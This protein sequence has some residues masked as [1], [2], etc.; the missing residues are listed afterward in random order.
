M[1][2]DSEL[3]SAHAHAHVP[4]VRVVQSHNRNVLELVSWQK[5]HRWNQNECRQRSLC[6][7]SKVGKNINSRVHLIL[8]QCRERWRSSHWFLWAKIAVPEAM[9][10]GG[11]FI[12]SCSYVKFV[13]AVLVGEGKA[14]PAHLLNLSLF[15]FPMC[16]VGKPRRTQC[17]VT[18][19]GSFSMTELFLWWI[20]TE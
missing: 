11:E 9:G 19:F 2:P 4:H 14:R 13:E 17:P 3:S 5:N 16:A 1:P 8:E 7:P 20:I 15:L 12:F 18:H 6:L 10:H